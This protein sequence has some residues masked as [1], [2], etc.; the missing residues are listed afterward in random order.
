MKPNTVF[1][2]A[3]NRGLTRLRD[4]P[5]A[6]D[7]G[8]EPPWSSMAEAV[9]ATWNVLRSSLPTPDALCRRV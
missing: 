6:S 8:S 7:I 1:K 3:Y 9:A 2:R 5:I 4:Y